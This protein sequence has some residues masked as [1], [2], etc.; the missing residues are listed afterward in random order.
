M[1]TI[2]KHG[3][4]PVKFH[5][6]GDFGPAFYCSDTVRTALRF[7]IMSALEEG[8]GRR[9]ASLIYFDVTNEDLDELTQ[10]EL[11]GDGWTQ[12]TGHCLGGKYLSAYAG[13]MMALQLV[14]PAR[15]RQVGAQP[16]RGGTRGRAVRGV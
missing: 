1:N 9:S 14:K 7:A 4:V 2:L 6:V 13:E 8:Y 10:T 15:E 3:I 16:A 11:E 12:L 5:G